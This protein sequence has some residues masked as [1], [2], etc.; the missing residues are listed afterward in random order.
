MLNDPQSEAVAGYMRDRSALVK[1]RLTTNTC[2]K[3]Y[4]RYVAEL[5]ERIAD[6]DRK[7]KAILE[8]RPAEIPA[9]PV[10]NGDG[11]GWI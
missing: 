5:D 9:T 11:S 1:D 10:R 4:H 8:G 6:I 7:V 3:N 2:W